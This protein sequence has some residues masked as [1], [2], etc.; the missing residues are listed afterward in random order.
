M[1]KLKDLY[2]IY[3]DILN[4]KTFGN[5][6]K[7]DKYPRELIDLFLII[8]IDL[9]KIELDKKEDRLI[10]ELSNKPYYQTLLQIVQLLE[11]SVNKIETQDTFLIIENNNLILKTDNELEVGYLINIFDENYKEIGKAI[12]LTINIKEKIATLNYFLEKEVVPKYANFTK[13]WTILPQEVVWV[14]PNLLLPNDLAIAELEV[15]YQIN[16]GKL[17][18][19]EWKFYY[20]AIDED[21]KLLATGVDIV[22]AGLIT[23]SKK[24]AL[25]NIGE[26]KLIIFD[27]RFSYNT[28]YK[29]ELNWVI[30]E[31]TTKI[32]N[33]D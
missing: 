15:Y 2:L 26:Y 31:P 27:R 24:N 22:R 4:S 32:T 18:R 21:L 23:I 3:L 16:K 7:I 33:Y 28:P 13:W 17:G 9:I 8:P 25:F 5:L 12:I 6:Y 30:K 1:I 29:K 14:E 10:S 11:F 20:K 19:V